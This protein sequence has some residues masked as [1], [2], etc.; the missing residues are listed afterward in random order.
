[1]LVQEVAQD[2]A[3]STTFGGLPPNDHIIF[4][5]VQE[6]EIVWGR[7]CGC[8]EEVG[9][10]CC[11]LGV[12]GWSR[13]SPGSPLCSGGYWLSQG[14]LLVTLTLLPTGHLGPELVRYRPMISG[15]CPFLPKERGRSGSALDPLRRHTVPWPLGLHPPRCD[16]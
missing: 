10:D 2:L 9:E 5:T 12:V 13:G 11:F 16:L 4:P 8:G 6:H 7:W 14:H 3:T 1:M 15:H